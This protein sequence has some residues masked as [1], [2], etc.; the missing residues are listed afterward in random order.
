MHVLVKLK[1][2]LIINNFELTEVI[3]VWQK[4]NNIK[5]TINY[6]EVIEKYY[7]ALESL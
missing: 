3:Q 6:N 2:C 4:V 5:A 1:L 7:N